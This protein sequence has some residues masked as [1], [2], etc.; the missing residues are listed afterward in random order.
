MRATALSKMIVACPRCCGYAVVREM[1]RDGDRLIC[2]ECSLSVIKGE[3]VECAGC[4]KK[5]PVSAFG[6]VG[7]MRRLKKCRMCRADY[8]A[9]V[10]ERKKV[11]AGR[12]AKSWKTSDARFVD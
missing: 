6:V 9:V 3:T 11:T 1:V 12:R 10:R 8:E 7:G 4:G 2:R 5:L